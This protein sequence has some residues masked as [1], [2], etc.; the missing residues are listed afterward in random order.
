MIISSHQ[1]VTCSHHAMTQKFFIWHSTIT[2]LTHSLNDFTYVIFTGE[3]LLTSNFLWWRMTFPLKW[4]WWGAPFFN[5]KCV[6]WSFWCR[7]KTFRVISQRPVTK[8]DLDI[9]IGVDALNLTLLSKWLKTQNITLHYKL[10]IICNGVKDWYRQ[11]MLPQLSTL[12]SNFF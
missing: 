7:R 8:S 4:W 5:F 9:S 10:P 11:N 6:S 12:N 3:S 2:T 1:N